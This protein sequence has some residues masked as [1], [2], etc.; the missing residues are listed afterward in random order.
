MPNVGWLIYVPIVMA[1]N[2]SQIN[3]PIINMRRIT[4]NLERL[5][6][7][8]DMIVNSPI[9]TIKDSALKDNPKS[10]TNTIY[11]LMFDQ[12]KLD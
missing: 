5:K 12:L 3:N 7:S 10:L 8:C 9:N 1:V 11:K 6:T 2:G 4:G